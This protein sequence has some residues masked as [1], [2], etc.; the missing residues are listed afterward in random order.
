MKN[1]RFKISF[2]DGETEVAT[3]D[4]PDLRLPLS[5]PKQPTKGTRKSRKRSRTVSNNENENP[6][7]TVATVCTGIVGRDA[8]Y[9]QIHGFVQRQLDKRKGNSLFICGCAGTGKTEC[10]SN[11]I[12]GLEPK[13]DRIKVVTL[14]GNT[15]LR[16][17]HIY[18]DLLEK[19]TGQRENSME[20]AR[21]RLAR[22]FTT[23]KRRLLY[24]VV[25]DEIDRLVTKHQDVLYNLFDWPK[26]PGSCLV[27]LAIANSVNLHE[28][29]LQR[30][31]SQ[32]AEPEFLGKIY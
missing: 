24:V 31:K 23:Q 27:L 16:S 32:K 2:E 19:I 21:N 15:D 13:K 14:N 17:E 4:D 3:A 1:K 7:T 25:I 6:N 30:L 9:R 22:L 10:V 8:E 20:A 12:N 5:P 29:F 26:R 28:R 11:V 18:Y